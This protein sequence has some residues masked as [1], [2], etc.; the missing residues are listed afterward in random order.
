MAACDKRW[1]KNILKD[2]DAKKIV[3]KAE[4]K[5]ED[6]S[7]IFKLCFERLCNISI[8]TYMLL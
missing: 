8:L 1:N 6:M 4:S 5:F 2:F 7:I 3:S